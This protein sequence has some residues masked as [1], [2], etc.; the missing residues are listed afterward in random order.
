M[1]KRKIVLYLLVIL[2]AYGVVG[3][4]DYE[5]AVMMKDSYPEAPP[6]YCAAILDS[7]PPYLQSVHNTRGHAIDAA[8][9]DATDACS[10]QH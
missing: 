4:M 6:S 10:I 5:D 9:G 3:R 8:L 2:C 7:S 1:S